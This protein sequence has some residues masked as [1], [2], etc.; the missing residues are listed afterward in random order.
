MFQ[1]TNAQHQDILSMT[2]EFDRMLMW[3]HIFPLHHKMALRGRNHDKYPSHKHYG[4]IEC[5]FHGSI[6]LFIKNIW[7][8]IL[9]LI[10]IFSETKIHTIFTQPK[11]NAIQ[12]GT[13][14][15]THALHS[16]SFDRFHYVFKSCLFATVFVA[17]IN[18]RNHIQLWFSIVLI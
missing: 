17:E 6:N 7:S 18:R 5:Y 14:N 1:L 10:E 9:W 3:L 11:R 13:V 8:F 15:R 2:S 16:T 4:E 12:L